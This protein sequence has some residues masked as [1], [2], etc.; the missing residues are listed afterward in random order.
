MKAFHYNKEIIGGVEKG[1]KKTGGFRNM[2]LE[3]ALL[4]GVGDNE[5]LEVLKKQISH[6]KKAIE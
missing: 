2:G 4:E 6:L 1:I 3:K 5:K